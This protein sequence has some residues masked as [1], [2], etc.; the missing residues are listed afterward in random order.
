MF[1]FFIWE[2]RHWVSG[3]FTLSLLAIVVGLE[4]LFPFYFTLFNAFFPTFHSDFSMYTFPLSLQS[5]QLKKLTIISI[6]CIHVLVA[7]LCLISTRIY[8]CTGSSSLASDH[9]TVIA[10]VIRWSLIAGRIPGR[11]DNE[12][13][14][15]W[16]T[17]LSKK[18]ISQGIDPRT[19]K[20]LNPDSS[21]A[22]NA[23]VSS[24]KTNRLP[25]P[26]PSPASPVVTDQGTPDSDGGIPVKENGYFQSTHLDQYQAAGST[27]TI[28]HGYT[29]LPNSDGSGMGM[30]SNGFSTEEDDDINY[31]SD[32]VFSSFLNSLI[33]EDAFT[34]Q[35]QLQQQPASG[36][37]P[38]SDPLIS[39]NAS[40]FALGAGWESA[41]MTSTFNQN[42]PK[43]VN[44]QM[45]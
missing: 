35:H 16:N 20:P 40:S 28:A 1:L 31:C 41:I 6:K 34:A 38:T 33:N 3:L 14:N 27:T 11:T 44:N 23:K 42:D 29:N 36:I 5:I 21:S 25:N 30:R 45:E 7:L 19:H 12:I 43:R 17:H 26:S 8:T 22:V 18:L 4:A 15:Y 32:D 39:I 2:T 10:W 13:K 9:C 37:P 24:S